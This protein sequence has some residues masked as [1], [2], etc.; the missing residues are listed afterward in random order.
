M[1]TS[2][3][4]FGFVLMELGYG[5]LGVQGSWLSELYPTYARTTGQNFVYYVSRA[6]GAGIAPLLALSIAVKMGFDVRMAISL[7][8]IGSVMTMVVSR[9]LP[10]TCGTEVWNAW[11]AN[12]SRCRGG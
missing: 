7:G 10:E 9:F 12:E 8:V 4:F 3:P 5:Y 1:W 6:V 11:H 2:L